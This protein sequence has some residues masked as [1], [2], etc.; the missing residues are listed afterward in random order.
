MESDVTGEIL[1]RDGRLVVVQ[2][3]SGPL[4]HRSPPW[5]ALPR[6]WSGLPEALAAAVESR[7]PGF[8]V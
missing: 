4:V 8:S 1:C 3:L 6:R 2:K 7:H 5:S